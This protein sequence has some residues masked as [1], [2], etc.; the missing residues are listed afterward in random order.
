MARSAAV[1]K[2][3]DGR[4]GG[5]AFA[6]LGPPAMLASDGFVMPLAVDGLGIGSVLLPTV[7]F[8]ILL[9]VGP[10]DRA[11]ECPS[12]DGLAGRDWLYG[13]ACSLT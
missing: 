5:S 12:E 7:P 2:V 6:I 10:I 1:A 8:L 9:F 11:R 13:S 3:V 4:G